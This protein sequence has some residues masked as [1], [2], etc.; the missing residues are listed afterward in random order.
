ME[1]RHESIGDGIFGWIRSHGAMERGHERNFLED[2][3]DGWE[4]V[5]CNERGRDG[6]LVVGWY[7]SNFREVSDEVQ[8]IC[9]PTR[10][11]DTIRNRSLGTEEFR[12]SDANRNPGVVRQTDLMF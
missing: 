6:R 11:V 8:K 4:F 5:E 12:Y 2:I 9:V 1:A 7:W 3:H 10:A